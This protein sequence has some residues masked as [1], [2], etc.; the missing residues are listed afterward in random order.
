MKE[1]LIKIDLGLA[2]RDLVDALALTRQEGDLG[3]LCPGCREPVK[4]FE[5]GKKGPHFEHIKRNPNCRQ[6]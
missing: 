2:V 6:R 3:F 5:G 1:C 4:P